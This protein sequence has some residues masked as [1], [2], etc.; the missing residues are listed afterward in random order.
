VLQR[1]SFVELG[2]EHAAQ[3]LE[4]LDGTRLKGKQIRVEYAKS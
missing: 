2:A 4:R 3:A 1:F